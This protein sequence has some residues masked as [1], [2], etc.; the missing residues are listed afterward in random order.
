MEEEV[1]EAMTGIIARIKMVTHLPFS[2][3]ETQTLIKTLTTD[4]CRISI[5]MEQME[6]NAIMVEVKMDTKRE[7]LRKVG[8]TS[9]R[10]NNHKDN[11]NREELLIHQILTIIVTILVAAEDIVMAIQAA[12][13]VVVVLMK[14]Q[15]SLM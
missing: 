12:V 1:K 8:I 10:D 5:E 15:D 13:A 7:I 4:I 6:A 9:N 14:T 3:K 2:K 11:S